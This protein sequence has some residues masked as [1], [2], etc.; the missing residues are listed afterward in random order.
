[1]AN[2]LSTHELEQL[3]DACIALAERWQREAVAKVTPTER[4]FC[5]FMSRLL[6]HPAEKTTLVRLIDQS[7]RTQGNTRLVDQFCS[8]LE[9]RGIPE[10]F[11]ALDRLLLQIFLWIGP[12]VPALAAPRKLVLRSQIF[13]GRQ[14]S[15]DQRSLVGA[16]SQA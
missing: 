8:V 7:F 3:R 12:W 2:S 6:A 13:L 14:E 11:P 9:M 5:R 4:R 10:A 15:I 16:A 1:M